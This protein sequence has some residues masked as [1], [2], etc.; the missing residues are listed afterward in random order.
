MRVAIV[1][2]L[3]EERWPSMDLVGD[4]LLAEL[5]GT[6]AGAI[7]ADLVRPVMR[8]RLSRVR[9]DVGPR[10]TADRFLNRFW[11]YPRHLARQRTREAFDV[12]HVVDHSYGQLVHQLPAART[13]VTCHDLDT[14]RCLLEPARDRRSPAFRAMTRRILGGLRRAAVVT[15]D[16]AA[17][18]DEI[19]A[20]GLLPAERLTVVPLGIHPT[21]SPGPDA[22]ADAEARRLL[23]PAG[24]DRVELLHVGS[25][26]PRKR[27]DVLL[28]LFAAVRRARPSA[29]LVRVGGAF[30]PEQAALARR[31][32][33][34]EAVTALP[35]LP[36]Q[37]LAAVYRRATL[38]LQPSSAEGFGLPVVEA[39]ACGTP[40]VASDLA[41][42]REVGGAA[43]TY[44]PVADVPAWTEAVLALLTERRDDPAAWQARR[45]AGAARAAAFSW[46]EYARR[47][48]EVYAEVLA[49]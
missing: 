20:H 27:L 26:V 24:G 34:D 42:L 36:R 21:C 12:F 37:V 7:A 3:A 43:A 32:G 44:R 49:A 39:L 45:A 1:C 10:F 9:N 13:V 4:M 48:V 5:R 31:L 17:V 47:M 2:D 19:L 40:V 11:D 18:R 23:G 29:R 41:V 16:S 46:S 15:C 30:T 25:T 8:R 22:A 28:G 14:F 38:V 6:H 33:V 35:F